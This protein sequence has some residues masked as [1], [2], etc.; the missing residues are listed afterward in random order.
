M[1]ILNN[2]RGKITEASTATVQKAKDVSETTK[3][4]KMISDSRNQIQGLYSEIGYQVYC[5][6]KENPIPEVAEQFKKV[7]EILETIEECGSK[8]KEINA[9]N[10]CPEC[11]AKIRPN[12]KFCSGCGLKLNMEELKKEEEKREV[13]YCMEC[14]DPIEPDDEYCMNCG[15]KIEKE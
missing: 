3:L 8:I 9:G 5:T 14:G 11:G 12:M 13:S 15:T 10:M 7:D 6:Y 4:N 1:S 2:L